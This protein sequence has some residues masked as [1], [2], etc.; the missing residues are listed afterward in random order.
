MGKKSE[1]KVSGDDDGEDEFNLAF[2]FELF[3]EQLM[4][5]GY[6]EDVLQL[7]DLTDTFIVVM[8]ILE[9]VKLSLFKD[10]LHKTSLY[11]HNP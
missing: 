8:D 3:D 5:L 6:A 1:F 10:L 11:K 7:G 4:R 9:V 2:F